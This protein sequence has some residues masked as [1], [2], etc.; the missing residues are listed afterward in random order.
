M[1]ESRYIGVVNQIVFDDFVVVIKKIKSV[2][3]LLPFIEE[4]IE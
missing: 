3:F 2:Y 1:T 4:A